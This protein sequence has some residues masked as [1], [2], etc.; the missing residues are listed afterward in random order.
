M[1]DTRLIGMSASLTPTIKA[2]DVIEDG[3]SLEVI[4]ADELDSDA[5]AF[6]DIMGLLEDTRTI[7]NVK[8]EGKANKLITGSQS[9]STL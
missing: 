4:A 2:Q 8:R 3:E 6:N 5:F 9:F 1:E 7:Y